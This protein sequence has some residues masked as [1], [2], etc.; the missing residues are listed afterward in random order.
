[1]TMTDG[2]AEFEIEVQTFLHDELPHERRFVADSIETMD[3][4]HATWWQATLNR[5]GWGGP[6]W[7][8]EHGGCGWS[9]SKL[10]IFQNACAAMGAP[11][12]SP[13]GPS[14]V[15][16]VIYTFG[17][18][19]QQHFHLARILDG[20]LLWCQ[21]YSEPGAGSD[22][23]SLR[24]RAVRDGDDYVV[25]GQKIWTTQAHWA[26]WIFCLVRTRQEGRPQ[27]G[28]SFLL[29]D[30]RSPG[31]EV[32][33][34]RSIDGQHHFN[35]V[36]FTGVRVPA[37]NLVGAE[38]RGWSYAKFLLENERMSSAAVGPL[39]S[40]L[41]RIRKE[42]LSTSNFAEPPLRDPHYR[43]RFVRLEER[44]LALDAME[45]QAL[46]VSGGP[47]RMKLAA[48]VKLAYSTLMQDV[49]ELAIDLAGP[50]ALRSPVDNAHEFATSAMTSFLFGR[51]HTIY[52]GTTEVQ[53]NIL[54][55]MFEPVRSPRVK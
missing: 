24:T 19:T 36:F 30:M 33:P 54:V 21:G 29:I 7:P 3:R 11:M 22:L 4:A 14:M 40:T 46:E 47:A 12:V 25:D 55:R 2:D 37:I 42:A 8:V 28:I 1:M 20:S 18:A 34:I 45:L 44:L 43:E 6:H 16:P 10:R 49:G 9:P 48:M 5:R 35:E 13:F 38:N 32:R 23:A 31:I 39:R 52:G 27:D 53:K 50:D 51:T 15:G 26:D 17:S 41:E